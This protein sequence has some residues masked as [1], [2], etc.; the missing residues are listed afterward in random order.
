MSYIHLYQEITQ[1]YN[2]LLGYFNRTNSFARN[3]FHYMRDILIYTVLKQQGNSMT[4]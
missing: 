3:P 1:L 2:R 4:L